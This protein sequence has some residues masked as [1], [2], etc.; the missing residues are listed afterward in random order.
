MA[1]STTTPATNTVVHDVTLSRSLSVDSSTY[2]I[3]R[4]GSHRSY[5]VS[6]EASQLSPIAASFISDD[7]S[8]TSPS[9]IITRAAWT[10][11]DAAREARRRKLVKIQAFL[12]E[13][14]PASAMSDVAGKVQGSPNARNRLPMFSKA[15]HKLQRRLT[16]SKQ[17]SGSLSDREVD[18][19]H[20]SGKT[21]KAR[22]ERGGSHSMDERSR[23]S[24]QTSDTNVEAPLISVSAQVAQ[25]QRLH[26][27]T[28]AAMPLDPAHS[29]IGKAAEPVILAVRRARK[30]EKVSLNW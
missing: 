8:I 27:S 5:T 14:V 9:A 4:R 2:S 19:R 23:S 11:A 6:G 17:S 22:D 18:T 28:N 21:L 7:G 15:S 20:K 13:R 10:E 3:S 30:L 1:R 25:R 12:G 29:D 16:K 24:S 26:T